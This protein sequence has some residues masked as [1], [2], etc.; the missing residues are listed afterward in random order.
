MVAN[1]VVGPCA[2]TEYA[3][4]T[5]NIQLCLTLLYVRPN[6]DNMAWH[7]T[8]IQRKYANHMPT[9]G[10][11]D[12]LYTTVCLIVCFSVP[13]GI[14]TVNAVVLVN[15]NKIHKVYFI[16]MICCKNKACWAKN[17]LKMV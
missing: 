2:S 9:G 4:T 7:N 12:I 11:L 16:C 17:F 3:K 8:I 6:V 1:S 10:Q 5:E 15:T 13:Y 14:L